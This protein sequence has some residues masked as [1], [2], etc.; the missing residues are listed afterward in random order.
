[1]SRSEG[2][3]PYDIS[4]AITMLLLML[5]RVCNTANSIAVIISDCSFSKKDYTMK[6]KKYL[7]DSY[8]PLCC[9]LHMRVSCLS[10]I[11]K[12]Q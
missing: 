8:R 4:S 3:F 2:G 6:S 12:L 7:S 1:M 9:R 11:N 10:K 5:C